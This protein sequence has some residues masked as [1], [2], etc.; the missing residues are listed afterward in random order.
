MTVLCIDKKIA[1]LYEMPTEDY[2]KAIGKLAAA[3][4]DPSFK[5]IKA[6]GS[7]FDTTSALYQ[8]MEKN[9]R[10]NFFWQIAAASLIEQLFVISQTQ[11]QFLS[12]FTDETAA[13]VT[14]RL[15]MILDAVNRLAKYDPD[16]EP[17]A[18]ALAPLDGLHA[19]TVVEMDKQM[20]NLK[21][22]ID[23]ARKALIK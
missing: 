13:N 12:P 21:D 17:V 18:Q 19:T 1:E 9:G 5:A 10:I 16:I 11:E 23:A 2:D 7:I 6:I 22:K 15:G 14:M 8:E 3:I 20:T 4:N